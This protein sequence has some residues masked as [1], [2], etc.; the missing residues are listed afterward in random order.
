MR[1]VLVVCLLVGNIA[2]ADQDSDEARAR[3]LASILD[4]QPQLDLIRQAPPPTTVDESIG[5]LHAVERV[6]VALSRAELDADATR[7]RLQHEEFE[8]KNAHDLV[9][10][11]H[12]ASV[13]RWN[14]AAVL[15]GSASSIVG[16]GTEFG[17]ETAVKWGN[18]I[19]IAGAAVAAAFSIVALVKRDKGRLPLTIETNLLAPLF[20]CSPTTRSRYPDWIWRYFDTPLAG[21]RTSIRR[22]L[23]DKWTSEGRLP[24]GDAERRIALLCQPLGTARRI[25]AD[26]LDHRADMLADVRERVGEVSVELERLWREMQAQR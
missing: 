15:V 16:A 25:D 9:E 23:I 13:A 7:A 3:Q 4:L 11:R 10:E 14:V 20:D 24:R 18:G 19:L 5:H 6:I 12:E 17:D 22:E 26:V 21:A 2:R 8:S 1:R